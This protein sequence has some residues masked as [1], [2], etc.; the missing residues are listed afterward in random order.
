MFYRE[1][2]VI[3]VIIC[4]ICEQKF[5]DPRVLPCGNTI[6]HKCYVVLKDQSDKNEH[7]KCN[8]C[9]EFH[10]S[11]AN[12]PVNKSVVD[13]LKCQPQA[14]VQSQ[15]VAELNVLLEKVTKTVNKNKIDKSLAETILYD[16]CQKV[17]NDLQIK[18][19]LI[20]YELGI[21]HQ[22][23][24]DEIE[25][26]EKK[27]K[28]N[29]L[30]NFGQVFFGGI[31]AQSEEF[32]EDTNKL[33]SEFKIEEHLL[34]GCIDQAYQMIG[35]LENLYNRLQNFIFSDKSCVFVESLYSQLETFFQIKINNIGLHF[36]KN[37]GNLEQFDFKNVLNDFIIDDNLYFQEDVDYITNLFSYPTNVFIPF[38]SRMIFVAYIGFTSRNLNICCIDETC[39][40][41]SEKKRM[42]KGEYFSKAICVDGCSTEK[43]I[44]ILT[45]EYHILDQ[46]LENRKRMMLRKFDASLDLEKTYRIYKKTGKLVSW[47]KDV[48]APSF[49]RNGFLI[50][51]FDPNESM[52]KKCADI[53]EYISTSK[54]MSFVVSEDYFIIHCEKKNIKN[55][56]ILNKRDGQVLKIVDSFEF[57][58]LSLY[59]K[60]FFLC[61]SADSNNEYIRSFDFEGNSLDVFTID[62]KNILFE[63]YFRCIF[64]NK[65]FFLDLNNRKML[66][67]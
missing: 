30:E 37:F 18:M 19:E 20:R 3:S 21:I 9:N 4:G 53:P 17:R 29:I 47:G 48:F 62:Q 25:D 28:K 33:L 57:L 13:L 42:I 14:V 27:C 39:K 10:D 5:E 58:T 12:L 2:N 52:F 1:E 63:K 23:L 8:F 46:A 64:K 24:L 67:F 40:L 31:I 11:G 44:F 59:S 43:S 49:N 61:F 56:F 7:Y 16:D 38:I 66:I 51:C 50:T 22:K 45:V 34:Q 55:I 54:F 32:C 6:C 41:L 36:V 65:L 60:E 15:K 26:Y 35:C